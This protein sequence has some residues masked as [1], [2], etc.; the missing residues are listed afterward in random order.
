MALLKLSPIYKDYIWG[1]QKLKSDF[2]KSGGDRIAES[3][4][5][6]CHEDGKCTIA[7]GEYAG[8]TLE[9]YIAQ[10]GNQILGRNFRGYERFPILVKLI[11]ARDNL[12]VQVHPDNAYAQMY[13]NDSGKT[14]MWYIL[15]CEKDAY[16]YIGFIRNVTKL[17]FLES[18]TNGK[19]EALIM[20]IPVKEGDCYLITPGTLHAIGK[21]IVLAEIQQSSNVTYRVFDYGRLGVDGKPRELHKQKAAE[22][23]NFIPYKNNCTGNG[24]VICSCE[25]F[26]VRKYGITKEFSY[27]AG[28][29]S[30][31][32][33]L[34]TDGCG[35]IR[36]STLAYSYHK[37]DCFF[38]EAE[39]EPCMIIGSGTV[40]MTTIKQKAYGGKGI[41]P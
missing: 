22:V 6:S 20:K 36:C 34:C 23:T 40:L 1:G 15:N 29:D 7:E 14:E 21:G 3:W 33:L 37:G 17:E 16:L 18:L 25:Y 41:N 4:E 35:E 39:S 30:F 9:Q 12:S 8:Y 2:H 10:K 13:E 31:A 28:A 11:D 38:L 26:E 24:D 5:L 27:R 19:V 32:C